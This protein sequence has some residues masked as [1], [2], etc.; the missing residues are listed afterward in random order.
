MIFVIKA[1]GKKEP[2]SE[3]KLRH[4]IQRAGIPKEMQDKV[5]A[6][7]QSK[8]VDNISTKDVYSHI[9]EFLDTSEKP[10]AKT[11]YRLKQA[12]MDLGPTGYPFEDY[13]A[14]LLGT[15]GYKTK[16]RQ[17]VPG[18]CITHEIDIVAEID[19]TKAMIEAKF[20]NVSGLKTKVHV[21]MYTKARFDD[22][23]RKNNFTQAWL[24]TNTKITE[25]AVE[26]ANCN[27]IKIIS[28]KYPENEGLRD[29]IERSGHA[30]ITVLTGLST[31]QKQE[32][33]AKDIVVC[34]QICENPMVLDLLDLS[35]EKKKQIN[36]ESAFAC[37]TSL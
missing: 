30:P 33:L 7:V 21:A 26:Y 22:V 3:D 18:N 36:E 19:N 28:W 16:V 5:V 15:Q 2:Y 12:I 13:I 17:I 10:F 32:L 6:H 8:L 4:S 24:V 11:R 37:K 29:L 27:N 35:P 1:N 34:K 31:A 23:Q 25:D 9:V 14:D 20:H